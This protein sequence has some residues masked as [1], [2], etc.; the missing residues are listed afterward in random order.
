M[1]TDPQ[2]IAAFLMVAWKGLV[3]LEEAMDGLHGQESEAARNA[4]AERSRE[5]AQSAESFGFQGLARLGTSMEKLASAFPPLEHSSSPDVIQLLGDTLT[6]LPMVL[7]NIA[8]EASEDIPQIPGLQWRYDVEVPAAEELAA[9]QA[10]AQ[11]PGP[12]DEELQRLRKE[13]PEIVS[14]FVP[15]AREHLDGMVARLDDLSDAQGLSESK[16]ADAINDFFRHA[17]T[18]K[19]AAYTVGCA[20]VG[21][22]AHN[23]ED[24]WV[25]IRNG[26][27]PLTPE[28][29]DVGHRS[30]SLLASLID[31]LDGPAGTG[32]QAR[33][34]ELQTRLGELRGPDEAPGPGLQTPG[35]TGSGAG[36]MHPSQPM[37]E[38]TDPVRHP[39][40][41]AAPVVAAPEGAP[42]VPPV[43]VPSVSMAAEDVPETLESQSARST[44]RVDLQRLEKVL[45]LA[46]EVTVAHGTSVKQLSRL[47]RI[48]RQLDDCKARMAKTISVFQERHLNPVLDVGDAGLAVPVPSSGPGSGQDREQPR[49][50]SVAEQFAELEFDRYD[51]FNILARRIGEL[52]SD[53]SEIHHEL[54]QMLSAAR[55]SSLQVQNLTRRLRVG[56]GKVRMVP[57]G[58]LFARF[59]LLARKSAGEAGKELEIEIEGE[60]VEID[61]AVIERIA[62]PL[63]HLVQNA[64]H[65]GL[66]PP[67]VRKLI[68]K[69]THGSLRFAAKAKGR[70]VL[71]EVADDG[72]GIDIRALKARAVELGFRTE[73]Q[74]AQLSDA[75]ALALVYLPGLTTRSKV[76]TAA[77]R[78]VGMDAVRHS[79]NR[80][81]GDIQIT[82]APGTGTRFIL[83][84]PISLL[85][86]EALLVRVGDSTFALPLPQVEQLAHLF[87][88]NLRHDESNA[89]TRDV[90]VLDEREWPVLRLADRFGLTASGPADDMPGLLAI[91]ALVRAPK[92]TALIVDEVLGI[93][94]LVVKPL[95]PFLEGAHHFSGATLDTHGN[96]ILMLD[97]ASVVSDERPRPRPAVLPVALPEAPPRILLADDS[98]S[99][100]RVLGRTLQKLGYEVFTACDGAEALELLLDLPFDAVITDLEMP[101][102]SGYELIDDL[103][104]RASTR[105]TPVWVITTRAGARHADLARDLGAVG[106]LAK[107]V[108]AELLV[109]QL[110]SVIG[111]EAQAP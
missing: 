79:V 77:G 39:Q 15:E 3:G 40:A 37:P 41:P 23:L 9:Q 50:R 54:E 95:G 87:A 98:L 105:E 29:V 92:P 17:H 10:Q 90:A 32:I 108:D 74:L 27:R 43:S 89:G 96:I 35:I 16:R 7:D 57:V 66:E 88:E 55:H 2:R 13:D 42:A 81:G 71:L 51:D 30:A 56:I 111:R 93:E 21:D 107:P 94:E 25:A 85:V 49:G 44:L 18:I 101:R 14:F 64:I 67:D 4:L 72:A 109:E 59:S 11:A 60:Q 62:E 76:T 28:L 65:H 36:P 97:L 8:A 75:E 53:L 69:E 68:G 19:G 12:V 110:E 45:D 20:V 24:I 26:D 82:S 38:P 47:E 48:H 33:Y 63:T 80:L 91:A 22:L 6:V 5:L 1:R 83:E 52:S 58:R 70:R 86:T 106:Y 99:V 100:R 46:G 102:M 84:L 73:D 103:R 78:G 61:N 34:D 104:N 31:R